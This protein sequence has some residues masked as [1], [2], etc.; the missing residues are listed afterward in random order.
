VTRIRSR[1]AGDDGRAASGSTSAVKVRNLATS[2]NAQFRAPFARGEVICDKYEVHELVGVGGVAFVMSAVHLALNHHVALKFLRPEF[3]SD[4]NA[5]RLFAEEARIAVKIKSAHVARVFDV[6]RLPHGAPFIAMELLTG[7]H[8]GQHLRAKGRLSVESVTWYALQACEALAA[9][10]AAGAIHRDIKPENLFVAVQKPGPDVLKVLDFGISKTF[11]NVKATGRI[12]T[13]TRTLISRGSPSYMSPEQMRSAQRI[14]LRTD[15]WSLG[16]VMYELL[17]GANPFT[18]PSLMQVCALVLE[19]NPPA[20]SVHLPDIPLAL[21]AAVM[22]CLEKDPQLRFRNTAELALALIPFAP[23]GALP[24]VERCVELLASDDPELLHALRNA[25]SVEVTP[26]APV[27][28][29]IDARTAAPVHA[30]TGTLQQGQEIVMT[31]PVSNTS[32]SRRSKHLLLIAASIAAV[33][34]VAGWLVARNADRKTQTVE[35]AAKDSVVAA[36]RASPTTESTAPSPPAV[37]A[38]PGAIQPAQPTSAIRAPASEKHTPTAHSRHAARV[39]QAP[40]AA[41]AVATESAPA[42]SEVEPSAAAPSADAADA[43]VANEVR[44]VQSSPAAPSGESAQPMLEPPQPVAIAPAPR[45]TMALRTSAS[46]EQPGKLPPNAIAAAIRAHANEVE[47]C[48]ERAQMDH[49]ELRGSMLFRA[50]IDG[51]GKVVEAWSG[52][53]LANGRHLFACILSAAKAWK[54]PAPSGGVS[55]DVSYTFVFE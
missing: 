15:I 44:T 41:P 25:R 37:I 21:E 32:T 20:L 30:T 12:P 35:H 47:G 13:I 3:L 9:A 19:Q 45:P 2:A 48:F 8:L 50:H 7:Q 22:R 18:A 14:D 53:Q 31:G 49:P 38:E 42:A 23:V 46:A 34:M 40:R 17:S 43:L 29:D 39:L 54:F 51:H 6:G 4:Q 24:L 5:L 55:G 26:V 33:A 27:A 16:C 1:A 52:N 36:G 28:L 11:I 10:H